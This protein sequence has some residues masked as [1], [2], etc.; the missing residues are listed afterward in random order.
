MSQSSVIGALQHELVNLEETQEGKNTCH[1]ASITQQP[2]LTVSLKEAQDV[3]TQDIGPIG[4][5][6][7]KGMMSVS[8]DSCIYPY[9]ERYFKFFN[10]GYLVSFN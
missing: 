9:K 7:N 1:Q 6:H 5:V 4:E 10:G 2:L 8:P 3:K